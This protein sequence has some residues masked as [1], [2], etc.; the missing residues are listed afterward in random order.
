MVPHA[1]WLHFLAG[2]IVTEVKP[3]FTGDAF[4]FIVTLA[5]FD[6]T[7]SIVQVEGAVAFRA[8]VVDLLPA[9]QHQVAHAEVVDQAVVRST[10]AADGAGLVCI[11][12]AVL[13]GDG[14]DSAIQNEA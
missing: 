12:E 1:S 11:C 4:V 14:A 3:A 8:D 9:T 7:I 10:G 2:A 13:D 5:I 6:L